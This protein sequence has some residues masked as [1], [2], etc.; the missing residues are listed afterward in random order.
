MMT[1]IRSIYPVLKFWVLNNKNYWCERCLNSDMN[2]AYNRCF[3][4]RYAIAFFALSIVL[5]HLLVL[6]PY[7]YGHNW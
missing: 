5:L 7:K 1:M 2:S 4:P 3:S 6:R